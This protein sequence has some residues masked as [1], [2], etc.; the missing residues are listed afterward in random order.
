LFPQLWIFA[1][2]HFPLVHAIR[3][4]IVFKESGWTFS[5]SLGIKTQKHTNPFPESARKKH[6]ERTSRK[7]AD[8]GHIGGRNT[9]K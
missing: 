9:L 4:C 7:T 1:K 2:K 5:F 3:F 6:G 8:A